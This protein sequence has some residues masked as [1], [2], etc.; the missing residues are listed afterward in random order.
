MDKLPRGRRRGATLNPAW[1]E[2]PRPEGLVVFSSL[3]TN[4]YGERW[5]ARVDTDGVLRIWG[6]AIDYQLAYSGCRVHYTSPI[7][8]GSDEQEWLTAM[9][10]HKRVVEFHT[11]KTKVRL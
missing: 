1:K 7:L 10:E 4:V 9:I 11:Q 8:M 5:Y 2:E 6:D 3:F